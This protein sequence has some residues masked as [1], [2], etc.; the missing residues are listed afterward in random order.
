[1]RQMI[2]GRNDSVFRIPGPWLHAATMTP[3]ESLT[4]QAYHA[5]ASRIGIEPLLG[6]ALSAERSQHVMGLYRRSELLEVS[7]RTLEAI[8]TAIP[9]DTTRARFDGIFRPRGEWIVDLHDAALASARRRDP[10]IGWE[11]ARPALTTAHWVAP[12][13]RLPDPEALPRA[14]YG[15]AVLAASD[16]SAFAA[17]RTE[18]RRADSA[19]AAAV[20]TLLHGYTDGQRWYAAALDFFLREPWAP[21]G[22]GRSIQ[23]YVRAEWRPIYDREFDAPPPQI[24]TRWFGYPQA[25]PQYGVPPTLFGRLVNADNASAS[26]WLQHHGEPGLLRVL[27]WLPPG[28]T[29]LAVL[30]TGSETL[31]LTT[32]SR[33]SRESLNGFLEPGD[34][35]AIDPGY[36]PLLALGA[37]VHEWQHLVFRRRQLEN[38]AATL[39]NKARLPV[40][41]PGVQ[42]HLAEGFAEWSSERI[43]RPLTERW[44]LLGFGE[45]EKRAGLAQ[46]NTDDQHAI[47]Y[48]LVRA[49]ASALSDPAATTGLLLRYAED[50]SRIPVQPALR[51]AWGQYRRAADRTLQTPTLKMLI[52]EVTFTIEDGFPDVVATRILVPSA[53]DARR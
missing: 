33:Q 24:E 30:R 50:P 26:E 36:S 5:A 20:L 12:N 25:V 38:F 13:D 37:L 48:T 21:D 46:R 11:A 35:I 6:P 8:R 53:D 31:R 32:V 29:T 45:L 34:A 44:P 18:L 19:S 43:L 23:D 2:I 27:R 14:L 4:I 22:S 40:R 9:S 10:G 1:L 42:P 39:E 47:G 15:L 51:K 28:D 7:Q 41:L 52:P 16:S 17:A 49:L 3:P